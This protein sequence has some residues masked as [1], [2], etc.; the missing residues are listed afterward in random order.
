[1][2]HGEEITPE[3]RQRLGELAAEMGE[4]GV[5]RDDP[6]RSVA[7][8]LG[9]RW[10]PLILLV[11]ETGTWRHA[12]LRRVVA[13]LSAEQALSQR[14][15]TLKLRALERDGFVRRAATGDVPPRVSYSLTALG[16][17]LVTE[18]RRTIDWLNVRREAILRNRS[19]FDA[20]D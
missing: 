7:A 8:M 20:R 4:G 13:G 15:M 11:L 3:T 10:S 16:R 9:D 6:A 1:M 2:E 14:I 19:A 18:L 12:D 17:E 5:D